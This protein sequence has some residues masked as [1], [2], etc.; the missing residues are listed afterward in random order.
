MP[1]VSP[2]PR[3]A[4]NFLEQLVQL[5]LVDSAGIPAFLQNYLDRLA[6]FIDTDLLGEALVHGGLLTPYQLNRVRAG[7]THGLV[8]GNYRVLD[9]LGGGSVG[10]VFLGEHILLKRKVAIK[11]LPTDGDF[12]QS[13]LDRF[14]SEMRVL[15]Q[16]DHPHIVAAYDAG[17]LPAAEPK[18]Q[19]LHY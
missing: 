14:Y 3:P 7:T 18:Q 17:V 9:R 12:P 13:V 1:S 15:A 4:R 6:A 8:L 16:L 19:P 10:V 11:V 5:Q 2:L